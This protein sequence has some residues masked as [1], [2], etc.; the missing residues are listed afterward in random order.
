MS[1]QHKTYTV[2]IKTELGTYMKV[3]GL[4]LMSIEKAEATA[5]LG[6]DNGLDTVAINAYSE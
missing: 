5:K 4:P 3:E 6:R 2:A 1:N